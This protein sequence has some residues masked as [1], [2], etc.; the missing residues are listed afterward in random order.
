MKF[1]QKL[2]EKY[3]KLSKREKA[4]LYGTAI[5]IGL[6]FVDRFVV[7]PT[8][9]KL[10]SIDRAIQDEE[11]AIK[12]SLHVLVQKNRIASDSREFMAYSVEGK[13]PEEEMT[14]LLQEIESLADKASVSLVYVKPANVETDR[15]VTKCMAT[16]ECESQMEQIAGFF[17]SIES[18]T[19]LLRIEKFEIQ[20]KNR[21]SSIAR[22]SLTVSKT[23][24]KS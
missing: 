23:V 4:I 8:H 3:H 17:H 20:P 2:S 6:L 22:C 18:S 21:E 7:A 15:D 11:T 24:V 13:S 1:G 9:G 16:L 12:K 5:I 10:A 14:T 19:K